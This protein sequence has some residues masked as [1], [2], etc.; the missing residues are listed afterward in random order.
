MTAPTTAAGVD[1]VPSWTRR[2]FLR[3]AAIVA[4]TALTGC[5]AIEDTVPQLAAAKADDLVDS[6]GVRTAMREGA[7]SLYGDVALV[8][9]ALRDDATGLGLRHVREQLI[10]PA[11]DAAQAASQQRAWP[12]LAALGIDF[13]SQIGAAPDGSDG[14]VDEFATY[15]RQTLGGRDG[16]VSTVE[17]CNEPNS[18]AAAW[19]RSDPT[20]WIGLC[21]SRQ[22][23]MA[24]RFRPDPALS[25]IR[26]AGPS[27]AGGA[28]LLKY[29]A[30][31][32]LSPDIDLGNFHYYSGIR[33]LS[34]PSAELDSI[35]RGV[36]INAPGQPVICTE[37]GMNQGR[38]TA[39]IAP[40]PEP[41]AA[42]YMPR[43][44]LDHFSRGVSRVF[45]FEL[46]DDHPDPGFTDQESHFGLL[47]Y[48]NGSLEPKLSY[49]SLKRLLDLLREPGA[50]FTPSGL[51]MLVQG[52]PPDYRQLLFQK[53]NGR[54][55]LCMWRDVS[56]WN[57]T[58]STPIDVQEYAVR[59]TLATATTINVYRPAKQ[60][61]PVSTYSQTVSVEVPLAG[62]VNVLEI[63]ADTDSAPPG[64]SI[65]VR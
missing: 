47:R 64:R 17:N 49:I 58:T 32:D 21:R 2:R 56:I 65:P 60:T 59:V 16:L 22:A 23:A 14:T 54:H 4:G 11:N 10:L 33:R 62:D 55:Y 57:Q 48:S 35:L 30:L 38:Q 28:G 24:A 19:N 63:L 5:S 27:L 45:I 37:T 12:Q 6:V 1:S 52:A 9:D 13:T 53:S 41:V 25:H 44:V 8:L 7:T 43:L 26:L 18:P 34:T 40:H 39:A 50:E 36:A 46:L 42:S 31:G 61:P 29:Q 51:A 20:A 3:D 15:L